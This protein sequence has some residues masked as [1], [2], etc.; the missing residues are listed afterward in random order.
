MVIWGI[1]DNFPS[2]G[3]NVVRP[4]RSNADQDRERNF[5]EEGLCFNV[6]QRECVF[7]FDGLL[8]NADVLISIVKR[9]M[10]LG[11]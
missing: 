8:E 1:T 10:V 9:I 7:L 3:D 2:G 4:K 6:S 5:E 11:S